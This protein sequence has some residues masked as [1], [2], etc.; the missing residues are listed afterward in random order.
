M[1]STVSGL[2][3]NIPLTTITTCEFCA[4]YLLLFALASICPCIH[5]L[6]IRAMTPINVENHFDFEIS[7]IQYNNDGGARNVS[8]MLSIVQR[9]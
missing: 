3:D 9:V 4:L 8:T 6:G 7:S 2:I 5:A 1:Q